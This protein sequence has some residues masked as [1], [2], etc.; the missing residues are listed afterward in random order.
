MIPAEPAERRTRSMRPIPA[1]L[2][3]LQHP[4]DE[5][6]RLAVSDLCKHHQRT[7]PRVLQALS[8]QL[9]QDECDHVREVVAESLGKLGT[10]AVPLLI[11]ALISI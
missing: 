9:L 11:T 5:M 1:L 7:D 2:R 4:D 3:A 6:R 10:I 8:E